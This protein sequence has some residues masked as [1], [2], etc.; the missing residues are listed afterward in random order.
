MIL[1]FDFI[2]RISSDHM[3]DSQLATW[4]LREPSTEVEN[5]IV[6][7]HDSLAICD[8]RLDGARRQDIVAAHVWVCW[9]FPSSF[10]PRWYRFVGAGTLLVCRT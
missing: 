2:G 8:Q 3:L 7:D 6:E 5:I 9:G 4:V 10:L 1:H